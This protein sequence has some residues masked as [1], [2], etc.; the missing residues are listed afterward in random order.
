LDQSWYLLRPGDRRRTSDQGYD[1]KHTVGAGLR[2]T[3]FG[4]VKTD[5][6]ERLIYV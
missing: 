6:P 2:R 4:R 3:Q 5:P 1:R